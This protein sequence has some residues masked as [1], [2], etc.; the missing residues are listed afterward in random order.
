[1]G[2]GDYSLALGAFA[3]NNNQAANSIAINAIGSALQNTTANSCVI[4]PLRELPEAGNRPMTYEPT[5][6][7][8]SYSPLPTSLADIGYVYGSGAGPDVAVPSG[9]TMVT[10]ATAPLLNIGT[11]YIQAQFIFKPTNSAQIFTRGMSVAGSPVSFKY[12]T[13]NAIQNT[14][15]VSQAMLRV[16]AQQVVGFIMAAKASY[17]VGTVTATVTYTVTKVA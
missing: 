14:Y 11:Y 10:L 9:A 5:S 6:G 1:L 16:S 13:Y 12:S 7:E 15:H 17:N 4:K 8:V 2:Q 3:G